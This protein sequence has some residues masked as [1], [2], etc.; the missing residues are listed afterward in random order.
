MKAQRV[1]SRKRKD[2]LARKNYLDKTSTKIIKSHDVIGIE[3]LQV[4]NMLKNHKLAETLV[5]YHNHSFET[6]WNI[7]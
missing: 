4:S 3:D 6:C 5:R 1:L 7:K 2:L